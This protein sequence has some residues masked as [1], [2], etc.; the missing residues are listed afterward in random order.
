MPPVSDIYCLNESSSAYYEVTQ[1]LLPDYSAG[2]ASAVYPA[3]QNK[4]V[5]AAEFFDPQ[6][7]SVLEQGTEAY[8]YPQYLATVVIAVDR[9][10]TDAVIRG[11]NDLLSVSE[12]VG[13]SGFYA[14]HMILS[15]VAYGLE[16]EGYT[17]NGAAG[18]LAQLRR[19]GLLR[20]NSSEP[21]VLIC[22]DF[23]AAAMI[24]E[25]RRIQITVPCEGTFSYV[26]GLLSV[27]EL[28]F[29]EDS[30]AFLISAGFR[31]PDGQ[32]DAA[33]YPPAAAY[34]TAA[35]VS[36]YK[37]FNT[38][39]LDGDRIFRRTVLNTR[40]YSSA[41]GREHQ[42]LPLLFIIILIVWTSSVLHRAV[43]KSVR[44]SAFLTALILLG[45]MTLRLIKYQITDET[46]LG[47]FLWYC[48]DLFQMMLSLVALQL[49]LALDKPDDRSMLK[50]LAVP[51]AAGGVL[52]AVVFTSHIHGLIYDIDFSRQNWAKVYEYGSGYVLLQ[53]FSLFLFGLAVALMIIKCLRST[54][55]KSFIF[56]AVFIAVLLVYAYGYYAGVPVARDSDI[57]MVS[58]MLALLFFE[59]A[60]RTGLIPINTKYTAFFANTPLGIQISGNDGKAVLYSASASEY[61][62]EVIARALDSHP[63]PVSPDENTLLFAGRIRGGNAVWQE[64][65]TTLNRLHAE[66][67]ESVMRLSAANAIL[68]EEEKVKRILAEENEKEQLMNQLEAEIAACTSKL[69]ETALKLGTENTAERKETAA[70]TA[71][72]LCYV[73]RRCSLFF[74]EQEVKTIPAGELAV[75]LDEL[76]GI[77]A[78]SDKKIIVSSDVRGYLTVRRASLFYS[79]FCSVIEWTAQQSSPHLLAHLGTRNGAVILRLVSYS[80]P[81]DFAADEEFAAAA[82][83]AGGRIELEDLDDAS[84]LSFS[85]PLEGD[86]DE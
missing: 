30:E 72:L 85:F 55:K 50:Q 69:T 13:I 33:L 47:L 31:L 34:E 79:F 43:Q 63:L 45:W 51:A 44:R 64:D 60:L 23:Q 59:S 9:D 74:R 82:A 22:Y 28:T 67:D 77:A 62:P 71:V 65:I 56:P 10:R 37:R 75:Y 81:K 19:K 36:D 52:V 53:S 12:E 68:T 80:D 5:T 27:K 1:K 58:G 24:K 41:D 21:A 42:F 2:T 18:L 39:C 66:V 70:W 11:W 76:A 8:W 29:S 14:H 35:A 25:G 46:V 86:A 54:H 6:A 57:T 49:A 40:L 4:G 61:R 16:G 83:E 20:N 3:F 78:Y 73:K 48:Y 17:L 38:V 32:C 84:A 15:A 26:R 7:L